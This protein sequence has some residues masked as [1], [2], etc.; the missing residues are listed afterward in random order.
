[1]ARYYG[2]ICINHA[3]L[4]RIS[5]KKIFR[6][7]VPVGG[8]PRK[9]R[10]HFSWEPAEGWGGVKWHTSR[11]NKHTFTLLAPPAAAIGS[12]EKSQCLYSWVPPPRGRDF[13]LLLSRLFSQSGQGVLYFPSPTIA[14]CT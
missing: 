8:H 10:Q 13:P 4:K 7:V 3:V 1:M 6:T 11:L 9:M 2:G 12:H 14:S 5:S